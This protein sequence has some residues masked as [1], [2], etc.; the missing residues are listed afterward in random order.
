[1]TPGTVR[2]VALPV[3][4]L[5]V[6]AALLVVLATNGHKQKHLTADF[7]STISLYPGAQVKILGVTVGKVTNIE[8]QG[9]QVAVAMEYDAKYSVP[10]NARAVIV[11]PSIVGDRYIQLTPPFQAGTDTALPDHAVLHQGQT[12]VPVEVDQI[13]KS[14]NQLSVA[15]GPSGA[16][17]KGALSHLLTVLAANLDGN[18]TAFHDSVQ[19][20]SQAVTTLADSRENIAGSVRHLNAIS[21]TLAGDDPE[22]RTL[23][24]LLAKVSTELNNQD[25]DLAG[26]TTSLNQAFHEVAQFV[27]HN[28]G[29]L[30]TNVAD[31]NAVSRTIANHKSAVAA[32]LD[33]APLGLTDL[34]DSFV[35]ENYNLAHPTGLNIN[36]MDT[37]LTARSNLF[38]NLSTQIGSNLSVLCASLP[39]AQAKQLAPLCTA[40]TKAGNDLGTLLS[41]ILT[42]S[43]ADSVPDHSLAT[44][45]N[46]L[47]R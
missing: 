1:M 41:G 2:R 12:T 37:A 36:G 22:V 10:T 30:T 13:Y 40:L 16:N 24:Q 43:T 20:L 6:I 31:L 34:W 17:S 44:L 27:R 9:D 7:S 47:V 45:L 21:T 23:A 32:E 46:G 18:G 28:R 15:L 33:L 3:V 35:A 26:A 38:E 11:P 19:G 29:V 5:A 42:Q 25:S 4:A 14:L 39:P 8:V